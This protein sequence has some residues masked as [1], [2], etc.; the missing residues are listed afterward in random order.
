M[1]VTDH[2]FCWGDVESHLYMHSVA[3]ICISLAVAEKTKT[4]KQKQKTIEK[5]CSVGDNAARSVNS[6]KQSLPFNWDF[7]NIKENNFNLVVCH[8]WHESLKTWAKLAQTGKTAIHH[9]S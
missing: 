5:S 4:K 7:R 8:N 3:L 1:T 6:C 2:M 9:Q